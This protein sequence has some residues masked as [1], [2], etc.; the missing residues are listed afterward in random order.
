MAGAERLRRLAKT[1]RMRWDAWE[2]ALS[3]HSPEVRSVL[4]TDPQESADARLLT[5]AILDGAEA[6]E[7]LA[8]EHGAGLWEWDDAAETYRLR[9]G[10]SDA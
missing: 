8:W 7:N 2:A 10:S 5:A 4:E 1:R 6:L 9:G 3:K